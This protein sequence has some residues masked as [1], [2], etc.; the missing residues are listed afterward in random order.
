M[1][2]HPHPSRAKKRLL[3][4]HGKLPAHSSL[5]SSSPGDGVIVGDCEALGK[6]GLPGGWSGLLDSNNVALVSVFFLHCICP[7]AASHW[8][9]HLGAIPLCLPCHGEWEPWTKLNLLLLSCSCPVFGHSNKINQD[10]KRAKKANW[11][12]FTYIKPSRLNQI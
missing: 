6:E 12:P 11:C 3:S 1:R 2:S 5:N 9:L 4:E 10:R 7:P 8:L